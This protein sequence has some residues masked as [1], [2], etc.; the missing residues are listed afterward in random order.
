M[1]R[2]GFP[3]PPRVGGSRV[4]GPRGR[5]P[6]PAR[7]RVALV[8]AAAGVLH[9][10]VAALERVN[11]IEPVEVF[12]AFDGS[13]VEAGD[14]VASV[15]IAPHVVSESTLARAES[16]ARER[17]LVSVAP[18]EARRVAV[19][20]KEALRPMARQRFEESVRTKIESLG[21]AVVSIDYVNDSGDEVVAALSPLVR[22]AAAVD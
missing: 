5:A 10:D 16:I 6:A 17:P 13:V 19:V 3:A 11:R 12:T 22:G 8:A 18:F 1:P 21:S 2:R 20:V 7:S 15:K 9:V 4:G 14:L